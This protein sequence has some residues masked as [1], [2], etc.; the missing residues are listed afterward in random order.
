MISACDL[1]DYIYSD[2]ISTDQ[3][4]DD[5]Q[6]LKV[7]LPSRAPFPVQEVIITLR[8]SINHIDPVIK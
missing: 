3:E 6:A 8:K 2:F 4:S 1:Q 5:G 7:S